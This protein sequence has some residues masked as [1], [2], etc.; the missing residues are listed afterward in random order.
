MN[1]FAGQQRPDKDRAVSYQFF[2]PTTQQMT[3]VFQEKNTKSI[4]KTT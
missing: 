1:I 4:I 2:I 3:P